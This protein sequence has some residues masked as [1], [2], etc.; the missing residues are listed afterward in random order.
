M[1]RLRATLTLAFVSIT[2]ALPAMENDKLIRLAVPQA[3]VETGLLKYMLPRFT[4]KTQVRF[5]IVAE[6]APAD[7]AFGDD[8]TPVF[9]G[10]EKT[11]SLA[12]L[13]PDHPG[14]RRF[15]DWLQSDVGGRAITGYTVDG[16][17]ILDV[18]GPIEDVVEEIEFD[19]NA[20]EGRKLARLNCGRCHAAAPEDR[21]S[22]IGSTPSFMVLRALG[23]WSERFQ[24]FY[25][26]NPHPSFTQIEDLT[27]PF[28]DDLPSPI[29]PVTLTLD[30]L[31]AIFAYVSKMAPAD[32]GRPLQISDN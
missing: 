6:N 8:G 12:A 30:D 26:L 32:L 4:L 25:A 22:G 9:T 18:P 7:A 3:L 19:G 29:V 10:P 5:E 21:M 2:L 31:E 24:S 27:E 23:D 28:P 11:W 16:A 15:K 20:A 17:Q 1:V 14:T 13:S